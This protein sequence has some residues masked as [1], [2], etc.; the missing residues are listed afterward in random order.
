MR[1]RC[2]TRGHNFGCQVFVA[3]LWL[4][5][6]VLF[7]DLADFMDGFVRLFTVFRVRR[8]RW[9]FAPRS[10]LPTPEDFEDDSWSS[11]SKLSSIEI[12]AKT[13]LVAEFPAMDG[14]SGHLPTPPREDRDNNAPNMIS[15][16]DGHVSYVKVYCGSNNPSQRFQH[17]FAF[18]PP[19]GY[20]YKWSAD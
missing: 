1:K 18:N 19:A 20:D 10:K 7:Y 17:P 4:L 5:Y 6:K 13:V 15:F 12:P 9:P 2:V 11:G 3:R 16:V 8:R 14:Y